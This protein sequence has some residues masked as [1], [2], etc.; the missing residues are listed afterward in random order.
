MT[1][2]LGSVK[3]SPRAAKQITPPYF[4][5]NYRIEVKITFM[6]K[7][8]LVLLCEF[9]WEFS[10]FHL[11]RPQVDIYWHPLLNVIVLTVLFLAE[12]TDKS[13]FFN[14]ASLHFSNAWKI[15]ILEKQATEVILVGWF[16]KCQSIK[17]VGADVSKKVCIRLSFRFALPA[18]M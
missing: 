2:G 9:F 8:Y 12:K 7:A 1:H 14:T 17:K 15:C 4:E 16:G 13:Y 11:C 5:N 3:P 18:G 10:F 6:L